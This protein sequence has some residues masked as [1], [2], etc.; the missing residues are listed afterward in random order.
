MYGSGRYEEAL[1]IFRAL[2]KSPA[3]ADMA[4]EA[5]YQAAWCQF[6][7]GRDMEAADAFLAFA[8]RYKD[9]PLRRDALEQGSSIILAAAKNF[10][11]WKMPDD[12]ARLYKKMEEFNK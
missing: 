8:E 3:P 1:D 9:S 7:I 10:E 5:Q 12:A 11:K 2:A 6:R 4:L